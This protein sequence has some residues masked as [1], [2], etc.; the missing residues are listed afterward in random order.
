[1]VENCICI[2]GNVEIMVQF[3]LQLPYGYTYCSICYLLLGMAWMEMDY[4]LKNLANFFKFFLYILEKL[5]KMDLFIKEI[6]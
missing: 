6:S 2:D 4:N 5:L 3:C 1:M